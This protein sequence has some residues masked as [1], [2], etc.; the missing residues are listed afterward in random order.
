MIKKKHRKCELFQTLGRMKTNL[1]DPRKT[2]FRMCIILVP[3]NSNNCYTC[4]CSRFITYY[5]FPYYTIY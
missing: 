2:L 5:L 1:L 4:Y 3:F